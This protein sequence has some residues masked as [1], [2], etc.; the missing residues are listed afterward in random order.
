MKIKPKNI[1]YLSFKKLC[2]FQNELIQYIRQFFMNNLLLKI[3]VP[4][5]FLLKYHMVN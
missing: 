4:Y 1:V 5:Y 2:K 3:I